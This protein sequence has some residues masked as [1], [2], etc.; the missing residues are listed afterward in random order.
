MAITRY[1][2]SAP[3]ATR[4]SG[5]YARNTWGGVMALGAGLLKAAGSFDFIAQERADK[6]KAQ[7][8]TVRNQELLTADNT[9]SD[10]YRDTRDDPSLFDTESDKVLKRDM[11]R[12][13]KMVEDD[14]MT[15]EDRDR[16]V[17][18]GIEQQASYRRSAT[19]NWERKQDQ[20]KAA[21]AELAAA[22]QQSS[23]L[24]VGTLMASPDGADQALGARQLQVHLDSID[25]PQ[26]PYSSLGPAAK[27]LMKHDLQKQVDVAA[28]S[29]IVMRKAGAGGDVTAYLDALRGRGTARNFEDGT[30]GI[31]AASGVRYGGRLTAN[32][33]WKLADTL[34]RQLDEEARKK[35]AQGGTD[36]DNATDR[37]RAAIASVD[38]FREGRLS[39]QDFVATAVANGMTM[40]QAMDHLGKSDEPSVDQRIAELGLE[41][42]LKDELDGIDLRANGKVNGY[43]ALETQINSLQEAGSISEKFARQQRKEIQRRKEKH[44]ELLG[45]GPLG[46]TGIGERVMNDIMAKAG[47]ATSKKIGEGDTY[48]RRVKQ[49]ARGGAEVQIGADYGFL[50]DHL[51]RKDIVASTQEA[52]DAGMDPTVAEDFATASLYAGGNGDWMR[53]LRDK[54]TSSEGMAGAQKAMREAPQT[55]VAFFPNVQANADRLVYT[56]GQLDTKATGQAVLDRVANRAVD[57]RK[58]ALFQ[59]DKAPASYQEIAEAMTAQESLLLSFLDQWDFA[60]G[61]SAGPS[62]KDESER[63][64]RTMQ[65]V[66]AERDLQEQPQ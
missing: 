55:V 8:A 24:A 15:P 27:E 13:D 42:T 18:K 20:E 49:F 1:G 31:Q 16:L 58:G 2:A 45:E 62:P 17:A 50:G 46:M 33:G 64:Q 5:D 10:L 28:I 39:P 59:K 51:R 54:G 56:N 12:W 25:D 6:K 9:L 19:S 34:E 29:S 43:E 66:K 23:T 57:A 47:G 61:Y 36:A 30:F 53:F 40:T 63:E 41:S 35:A 11:A 14:K 4:I 37:A 44:A 52:I 21:Q 7:S 22:R 65:R 60:L 26:G 38:A 48:D 3:K 32:E